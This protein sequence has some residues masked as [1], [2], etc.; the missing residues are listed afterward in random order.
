MNPLQL[1]LS[2]VHGN[3]VLADVPKPLWLVFE[4]FLAPLS[5]LAGLK[6]FYESYTSF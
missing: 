6:P 3:L 5:Q 1:I 2:F 4:H